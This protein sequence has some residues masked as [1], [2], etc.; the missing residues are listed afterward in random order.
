MRQGWILLKHSNQGELMHIRLDIIT[1]FLKLVEFHPISSFNEIL[2]LD[3]STSNPQEYIME[4]IFDLLTT[5]SSSLCC[6]YSLL[7]VLLIRH[8]ERVSKGWYKYLHAKIVQL[9]SGRRRITYGCL[10]SVRG[11]T[12]LVNSTGVIDRSR[13]WNV[14]WL[15]L[16]TTAPLY[17]KMKLLLV[18][19]A[20]LTAGESQKK[21]SPGVWMPQCPR[22]GVDQYSQNIQ[23]SS[24]LNTA[25]KFSTAVWIIRNQFLG[26]NPPSMDSI[27]HALQSLLALQDIWGAGVE[28][29]RSLWLYFSRKL[30]ALP[31]LTRQGVTNYFILLEN[32]LK[33]VS[34]SPCEQKAV[35]E[36]TEFVISLFGGVEEVHLKWSCDWEMGRRCAALEGLQKLLTCLLT[37][38]PTTLEFE[39]ALARLMQLTSLFREALLR[40]VSGKSEESTG[41]FSNFTNVGWRDKLEQMVLSFCKSLLLNLEKKMKW[42]SDILD[43]SLVDLL[44]SSE[45]GDWLPF[46]I[47]FLS[48]LRSVKAPL[49][50]WSEIFPQFVS[51]ACT[52]SS[53]SKESAEVAVRFLSIVSTSPLPETKSPFDILQELGFKTDLAF[54]FR[55]KFFSRL[56]SDSA[57]L[58]SLLLNSKMDAEQAWQFYTIWL[59]Y[60][61]LSDKTVNGSKILLESLSN[62]GCELPD[63]V[64]DLLDTSDAEISMIRLC[65]RF[66]AAEVDEIDTFNDRR[67]SILRRRF[68]K[69]FIIRPNT[70]IPYITTFQDR[71]T[72]KSAILRRLSPLGQLL[73][74]IMESFITPQPTAQSYSDFEIATAYKATASLFQV[75]SA[76]LYSPDGVF[77]KL[78]AAFLMPPWR[79]LEKEAPN[80]KTIIQNC[81][82]E[83]LPAF[84]H[85]IVQL[86]FLKDPFTIRMLRE[87]LRAV[88]F[89]VPEG[90]NSV[91]SA[92]HISDPASYRAHLLKVLAQEFISYS[93]KSPLSWSEKAKMTWRCRFF[94]YTFAEV[95]A[96]DF[97]LGK[98]EPFQGPLED[99]SIRYRLSFIC[100]FV[101]TYFIGRIYFSWY[102]RSYIMNCTKSPDAL[103][104]TIASKLKNSSQNVS[105]HYFSNQICKHPALASLP[106]SPSLTPELWLL[107]YN[108]IWSALISLNSRLETADYRDAP[109]LLW[110]LA[111]LLS[112]SGNSKSFPSIVDKCNSVFSTFASRW[113]SI[114]SASENNL[115]NSELQ[116]LSPTNG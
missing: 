32:M 72:F 42:I 9:H 109:F 103:S 114:E 83:N 80:K 91:V 85:G 65:N 57:L 43:T 102:E 19:E 67:N 51:R 13:L 55:T 107:V 46:L 81:V 77:N 20:N 115:H 36:L 63:G 62:R 112:D 18:P 17:E 3:P 108:E 101:P 82:A 89:T 71:M 98:K 22:L 74:S 34:K 7:W 21:L 30:I 90:M 24:T 53:W 28:I 87:L 47:D 54:S 29:I 68:S 88:F 86:N 64:S 61:L 10:D 40:Q 100:I 37:D 113:E 116:F 110:P 58:K 48:S 52:N 76:L 111:T 1:M 92:I 84:L 31:T 70:E 6:C 41:S 106:R 96:V 66:E 56:F 44:C 2:E 26:D 79:R 14:Y 69:E 78:F 33:A 93:G 25:S 94:N 50:I 16:V 27:R 99:K 39:E 11:N 12:E 38:L 60:K 59:I 35:S 73:N 105:Q 5:A 8:G 45:R 104:K 23:P 15:V 75:T 49:R 4:W 95:E 97:A